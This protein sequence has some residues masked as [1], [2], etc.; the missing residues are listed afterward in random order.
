[1][2]SSVWSA[3]LVGVEALPVEIETHVRT[4]L[5]GYAVVGLPQTS[6]RESR[7]RVLSAIR[8]SNLPI[9]R[10]AITVSM[11]PAD[12]RKEGAL[13]DLPLALGLLAA[14]DNA[15]LLAGYNV[16]PAAGNK[17]PLAAALKNTF[18]AGELG[19]DGRLR[20][21]RGV[22]AIAELAVSKGCRLIVPVSNLSEARL[23]SG[24]ASFGVTNLKEAVA[25][26]LG[27]GK[28]AA[29]SSAAP[30]TIRASRVDLADVGGQAMAKRALEI[31]A[32]G[33]HHLLFLGPPGAGKTMLAKRLPGILPRMSERE[34]LTVMRIHSVA[35]L[36]TD[37]SRTRMD[38]PF[39]APHHSVS[40][41][42]L[43]GGGNPPRPGELTL[44]THGV[45]FL[46]ELPEFRRDC[47][48]SLRQPLES[49]LVHIRRAAYAVSFPA[50]TQLVASM[51]PCPCGFAGVPDRCLCDPL[52]ISRY[53]S[54]VSGPMLD[55]IDLVIELG[56]TSFD[57][58]HQKVAVEASADVANRV[59][60]TREFAR[61]RGDGP[62]ITD[63]AFQFLRDAANKLHLTARGMERIKHVARTIADMDRSDRVL[64][65]HMSESVQ[66]R[67]NAWG[68]R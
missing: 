4:G 67:G 13:F 43:I 15:P 16:P 33:G 60:Q 42:G 1:M 9:P 61:G 10:G 51:N 68:S 8:S 20:P 18:L 47:L 2:L 57:D 36:L 27:L 55:R 19:L 48:E 25:V 31:A 63:D 23:V 39:R 29:P 34:A 3:A 38:R 30:P 24:C 22:I 17:T 7:E 62:D 14:G 21:V 37:L 32:V 50:R 54:R 35:G 56:P 66:Y 46:D 11:A 65:G 40:T 53:R 49:G 44:A 12:L 41:A 58:V 59:E 5:P 6:V 45:L 26:A 52:Q 64:T 28:G